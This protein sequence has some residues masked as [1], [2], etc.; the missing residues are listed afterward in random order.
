MGNQDDRVGPNPNPVWSRDTLEEIAMGS[1][2]RVRLW[3]NVTRME[4]EK[5]GSRPNVS[6]VPNEDQ[7]SSKRRRTATQAAGTQVAA[8]R[9]AGRLTEAATT[10]AASSAAA[11]VAAR[12]LPATLEAALETPAAWDAVQEPEG[13]PG[14]ATANSPAP[15]SADR[16]TLPD[17]TAVTI[18]STAVPPDR[19]LTAS[20]GAGV[21]EVGL[22]TP[23]V[24]PTTVQFAST[25]IRERPG[26]HNIKVPNPEGG[27]RV[28][29][30]WPKKKL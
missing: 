30:H 19:P 7:P 5:M 10:T 3:D 9:S 6:K 12:P 29:R 16:L 28:P 22:E 8:S 23:S 18:E 24:R 4:E 27:Q 2:K 26:Y 14:P 17:D 21:A 11:V 25:D 13:N 15:V 20:S 1:R